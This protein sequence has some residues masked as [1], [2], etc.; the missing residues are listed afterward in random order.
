MLG[1]EKISDGLQLS[2]CTVVA[3]AGGNGRLKIDYFGP[4]IE[5][6]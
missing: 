1:H 6:K 4:S 5:E 2:E 3:L